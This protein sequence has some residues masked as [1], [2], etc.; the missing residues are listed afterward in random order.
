MKKKES[1][2]QSVSSWFGYAYTNT[3]KMDWSPIN[4]TLLFST[5]KLFSVASS[6]WW[7]CCS[8]L[9]VT[10]NYQ[11]NYNRWRRGHIVDFIAIALSFW[12]KSNIFHLCSIKKFF[13][14]APLANVR[15]K[16]FA[17]TNTHS[18]TYTAV[19]MIAF[20]IRWAFWINQQAPCACDWMMWGR[21]K[22]R[23]IL[24]FCPTF[25]FEQMKIEND[26]NLWEWKL[27]L[28]WTFVRA[29]QFECVS[30]PNY[31]SFWMEYGK[32]MLK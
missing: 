11:W 20:I 21:E 22:M 10:R 9:L 14:L 4:V 6:I 25:S 24:V 17:S 30:R 3:Q 29:L 1:S 31:H 7:S 27:F 32:W 5:N 8:F 12:A 28:I 16:S 2:E 26:E 23:R 19:H 13:V 18:Y 15:K